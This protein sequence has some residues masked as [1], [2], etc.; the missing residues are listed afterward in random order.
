MIAKDIWDTLVNFAD[1]I[2]A[3]IHYLFKPNILWFRF[4]A[5]LRFAAFLHCFVLKWNA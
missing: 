1:I 4:I 2:L 5:M 3:D